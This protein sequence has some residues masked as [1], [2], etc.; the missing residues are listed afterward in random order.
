MP[1]IESD[2]SSPRHARRDLRLKYESHRGFIWFMTILIIVAG[3]V[4]IWRFF[5]WQSSTANPLTP[6]VVA[7][8]SFPL[9]Y[10]TEVP[11]GFHTDVNSIEQPDNGV[12]I[13]D[14]DGAGKEKIYVSQEVPPAKFGFPGF[15][16]SFTHPKRITDSM[17]TIEAGY[18]DSG[19]VAIASINTER[20]WILANTT[21]HVSPGQLI[22]MLKSLT[23]APAE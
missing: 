3:S 17:G 1:T 9:Y 11:S 13:F 15:Y 8:V 23:L 21:A 2:S 22:T 7:S 16:A 12:I 10:P 6:S 18:T 20:T 5:I 14:V 4:A 19:Q